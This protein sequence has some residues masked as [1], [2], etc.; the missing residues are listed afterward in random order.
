MKKILDYQWFQISARQRLSPFPNIFSMEAISRE[1]Q[2]IVGVAYRL[3]LLLFSQGKAWVFFDKKDFQRVEKIAFQ[4]LLKDP[5]LFKRLIRKEKIYGKEFLRWVK[6]IAH[7]N[8]KKSSNQTLINYHHQYIKRYKRVYA[9]YFLI[10][11]LERILTNY[12]KGIIQKKGLSLAEGEIEKYFQILTKEPKSMV[13]RVE[14]LA[15]LKL[16]S[17]IWKNK[18]WREIFQKRIISLKR[19]MKKK[20]K[21]FGLLKKHHQNFFLVNQG[22]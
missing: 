18:R 8:L 5:F 4:K 22:L 12:L 17:L 7:S 3:V 21:L 14:E 15:A 19:E 11:S 13:R 6:K 16:A 2:K 10:I 20:R 1:A 9:H